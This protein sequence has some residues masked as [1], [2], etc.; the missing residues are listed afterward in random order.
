[1]GSVAAYFADDEPKAISSRRT[2]R[3]LKLKAK[4]DSDSVF[5]NNRGVPL[6]EWYQEDVLE[7]GGLRFT[8]DKAHVHMTGDYIVLLDKNDDE[9]SA[10]GRFARV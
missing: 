6:P 3:R 8:I 10:G 7:V 9:N 2:R 1:M 5:G 4:N